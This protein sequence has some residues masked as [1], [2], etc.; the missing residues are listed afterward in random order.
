MTG[1]MEM[2]TFP[3]FSPRTKCFPDNLSHQLLY[4]NTPF[5]QAY[6]VPVTHNLSDP[7]N[8]LSLT[9]Q[10]RQ[11]LAVAEARANL[12]SEN[13]DIEDLKYMG[14]A[15]VVRDMDLMTRVLNGDGAKM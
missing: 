3:F 1:I 10:S 13:M 2:L 4:E 6:T 8:H 5:V 15:T 12:C 14:T 11:Y 9:E 7:L